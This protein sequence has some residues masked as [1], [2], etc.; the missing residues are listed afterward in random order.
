MKYFLLL[1][2]YVIP[3]FSNYYSQ[4]GQDK[5]LNEFIFRNKKNGVFVDI[6]AHDGIKF[7]NSYFFEKEKDWSGICIEANPSVFHLLKQNRSTK[8]INSCVTPFKQTQ[9]HFLK[10]EGYAEMLSGIYEFYDPR[11]LLRIQ[12]EIQKHGGSY[13]LLPIESSPL[14]EILDR[15]ALY[16]IDFISLD[17]EG[18]ELNI[19]KSIDYERF[20]IKVIVVENNYSDPNF[21]LFMQSKGYLLIKELEGDQIFLKETFLTDFILK[22]P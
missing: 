18:G 10:I 17:I 4:S 20:D 8:C 12:Q 11:H 21:I 9:L 19:L 13:Q 22:I 3:V 14:S 16:S 7:S 2:V 1:C 15:H 5:F 6:G